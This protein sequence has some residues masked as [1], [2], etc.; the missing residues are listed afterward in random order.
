MKKLILLTICLFLLQIVSNAQFSIELG[1]DTTYCLQSNSIDTLYLGTNLEIYNG[2]PPFNYAWECHLDMGKTGHYTA[3]NFLNDS[4]I[5]NPYF[6]EK[7]PFNSWIKYILNVKDSENNIAQD[8]IKVRFSNFGYSLI[9]YTVNL[10][11]GDSFQFDGIEYITGGISPLQFTWQPISG[12]S[13]PNSL[14]SWCKPDTSTDYY[15]VA[16]DNIGCISDKNLLYRVR[17]QSLRINEE[18]ANNYNSII[19]PVQVGSNILFNNPLNNIAEISIYNMLGQKLSVV[20]TT[21]N[22]VD[23]QSF[24]NDSDILIIMIRINDKI[25]ILKYFTKLIYIY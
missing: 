14:F 10:C 18:L 8:S 20:T 6:I 21:N 16:S 5:S 3:S 15:Q 22:S 13:D 2:K 11:E 17:L 1:N 25:G 4:T 12:L 9:S 7:Y 23:L 19:N 24:A